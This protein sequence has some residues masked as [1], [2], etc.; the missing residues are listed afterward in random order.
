M[1]LLCCQLCAVFDESTMLH[2]LKVQADVVNHRWCEELGLWA[3]TIVDP[4]HPSI[5]ASPSSAI[6]PSC[7]SSRT[8]A[9]G[10]DKAHKTGQERFECDM[11]TGG[12]P[13]LCNRRPT[14]TTT[15]LTIKPPWQASKGGHSVSLA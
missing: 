15:R 8:R 14:V 11:K 12:Q 13:G 3:I 2:K 9:L 10:R 7:Q 6:V 4:S 5:S 1:L